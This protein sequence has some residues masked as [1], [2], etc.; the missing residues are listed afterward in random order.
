M[1]DKI[2]LRRGN[3]V[4]LP[5]LLAGE[6]GFALDTKELYIGTNSGNQKIVS[7]AP[8]AQI[9]IAPTL[10][11][12]WTNFDAGANA[13]AGYYKDDLGIVHLRGLIKGGTTTAGT[14]VL[15]LPVGYRPSATI[16]FPVNTV[17]G[18]STIASSLAGVANNGDL[19]VDS[20][21]WG[22]TY[23]ALDGISFRSEQ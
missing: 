10:L 12:S 2:L 14:K 1:A 23:V 17:S 7:A 21:P 13:Q 4:D 5:T 22:N 6:P 3:R 9:W 19:L 8:T 11:N 15:T 20:T 18:V 16:R